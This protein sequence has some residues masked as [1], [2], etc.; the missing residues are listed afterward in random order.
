MRTAAEAAGE[1]H[2]HDAGLRFEGIHATDPRDQVRKL[3]QRLD[4]AEGGGETPPADLWERR[5][6]AESS[7]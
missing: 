7:Y 6:R 4:D 1:T 5:Q 3:R 2:E